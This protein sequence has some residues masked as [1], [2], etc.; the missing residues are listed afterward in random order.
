MTN[1]SKSIHLWVMLILL[2]AGSAWAQ[3]APTVQWRKVADEPVVAYNTAYV[4]IL[5]ASDGEYQTL[6]GSEGGS[7][8]L[9]RLT[10]DGRFKVARALPIAPSIYRANAM[11]PTQ[12]GGYLVSGATFRPGFDERSFV[13][14]LDAQANTIWNNADEN[15]PIP[16]GSVPTLLRETKLVERP[17]YYAQFV[18]T[19][20]QIYYGGFRRYFAK[21]GNELSLRKTTTIDN[22]LAFTRTETISD[23]AEAVDG[24]I[25]IGLY[26]FS[27]GRAYLAKFTE[28][29][30]SFSLKNSPVLSSGTRIT[31][32]VPSSA[33]DGYFMTTNSDTEGS[34]LLRLA[35]DGS[36]VWTINLAFSANQL[37]AEANGI[38]VGGVKANKVVLS[39]YLL[40]GTTIWQTETDGT[41]LSALNK[42]PDGGYIIGTLAQSKTV[43][44][45][46][47]DDVTRVNYQPTFTKF[48][49][50]QTTSTPPVGSLALLEPRFDC[51]N[52]LA[53]FVTGGNG[54][55]EFRIAGL[56]DWGNTNIFS[57]PTYQSNG[58]TFTLEARE[59]GQVVSRTF[60]TACGTTPPPVPPP[61]TPPVTPPNPLPSVYTVSTPLYNCTTGQ[62][63]ARTSGGDGSGEEFRIVGLRDWDRNPFFT[64]PAWQLTNTI[65][66]I[67][68]RLRS[69][70]SATADF[71]TACQ[72]ALPTPPVVTPPD[73]LT[74]TSIG[75]VALDCSTGELLVNASPGGIQLPLEYRIPGLADWQLSNRFVVPTWQRNGTNFDVSVRQGTLIMSRTFTTNCT[76]AARIASPELRTNWQVEVLGNPV[77]DQVHVRITGATGQA[78]R[79]QLTDISGRLIEGRAIETAR[80]IEEQ[81]FGL[82]RVGAGMLLLQTTSNGQAK[83]MKVLK[84]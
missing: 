65:F 42:T 8:L 76:N 52:N 44:I 82:E 45:F 73:R 67:E 39:K 43:P 17:G 11:I 16:S 63:T 40:N 62:L 1:L 72:P 34:K 24:G 47:Q 30:S 37:V 28:S 41:I 46:I 60:T 79:F 56:R 3:S 68:A 6:I 21:S 64:V 57:V 54:R 10:S 84:Q 51:P 66:T 7:S 70:R 26:S 36:I 31:K 12:D 25:V 80:E 4:Q 83:T 2:G 23:V 61:V 5:P 27:G 32:I 13:T 35:V 74:P 38:V 9:L 20:Y 71:T 48:S 15:A 78:L 55:V 33:R 49:P 50:E 77:K 75:N 19:T 58:T 59:N 69:G 53:L 22:L 14:K 18:N 81:Q 29:D